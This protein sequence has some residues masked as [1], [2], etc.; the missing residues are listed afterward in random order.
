MDDEHKEPQEE[1]DEMKAKMKRLKDKTDRY[2]ADVADDLMDAEDLDK[3]KEKVRRSLLNDG[4]SLNFLTL[5]SFTSGFELGMVATTQGI[6]PP[7]ISGLKKLV[8]DESA[9]VKAKAQ[10]TL[11]GEPKEK[12]P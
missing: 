2:M 4:V 10:A 11:N 1:T 7:I 12:H 3:L 9:K 6:M 5:K 8:A